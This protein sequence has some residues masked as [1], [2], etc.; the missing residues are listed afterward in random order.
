MIKITQEI[1]DKLVNSCNSPGKLN[2]GVL[3]EFGAVIGDAEFI[4][5]YD[6]NNN[7][8]FL[9][10]ISEFEQQGCLIRLKENSNATS[11]SSKTK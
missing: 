1:E 7:G 2:V 4:I 10:H 6:D 5:Y 11:E 9:A 3:Y 8:P